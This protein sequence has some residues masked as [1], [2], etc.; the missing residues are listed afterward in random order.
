MTL[1]PIPLNFC[2]YEDFFISETDEKAVAKVPERIKKGYR[3]GHLCTY[4]FKNWLIPF[5]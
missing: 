3:T 1:H 4:S 5:D 2:I